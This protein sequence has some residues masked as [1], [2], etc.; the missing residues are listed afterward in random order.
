[1]KG[2]WRLAHAY[3]LDILVPYSLMANVKICIYW[4]WNNYLLRFILRC[5]C[6]SVIIQLSTK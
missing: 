6:I 3:L 4:Y 2:K 1:M 5:R